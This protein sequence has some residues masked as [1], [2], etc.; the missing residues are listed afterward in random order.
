[1]STHTPLQN[2]SPADYIAKLGGIAA[3]VILIVLLAKYIIV[4]TVTN[5]FGP[6]CDTH[7]CP[8]EALS[9]FAKMLVTSVAIIVVA[10]PEGIPLAV[11][12]ALMYGTIRIN[13]VRVLASCETMGGATT[14]CSDKTGTLTENRMTVVTGALV[15][16]LHLESAESGVNA[17]VEQTLPSYLAT[18][19]KRVQADRSWR[20]SL[21]KSKTRVGARRALERKEQESKMGV[22]EELASGKSESVTEEEVAGSE[23]MFE[24]VQKGQALLT[25]VGIQDPVRKGCT[26][27]S[28][29]VQGGGSRCSNGDHLLTAQA[30]ARE[31]GILTPDGVVMEGP[32]F[33]QLSPSEMREILPKLQSAL[34][35]SI[36]TNDGPALKAA[37]L[38]ILR[39]TGMGISG[40]E[41][42]KEASAIVLMDGNFASIVKAI[43]WGRSINAAVK[44]F[45]QFQVTVN[46]TA[47]AISFVSGVVDRRNV[48][49][50]TP[51]ARTNVRMTSCGM[52]RSLSHRSH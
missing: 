14:P 22:D 16:K 49:S 52:P 38:K 37:D 35:S 9:R 1:M 18:L 19:Q 28:R 27:S 39:S 32:R 15:P 5:E 51:L 42:A 3:F 20:A 45:L 44:K 23:E 40:T 43:M 31:C 48:V 36:G 10:I 7:A 4:T 24:E 6:D 8:S 17:P 12:L 26:G 30:I 33:R 2:P 34:L 21:A 46:I 11:S 13:F 50:G 41:V 29:D 47:V 25:V